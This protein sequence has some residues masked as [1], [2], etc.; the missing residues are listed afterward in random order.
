MADE[1]FA[2]AIAAISSLIKQHGQSVDAIY[3]LLADKKNALGGVHDAQFTNEAAAQVT[4]DW[5]IHLFADVQDQKSRSLTDSRP[6]T[7]RSDFI[8]D[9]SIS[10]VSLRRKASG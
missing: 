6:K 1:I 7:V 3:N 8:K 4:R 5:V 2:N 10:L 9:T